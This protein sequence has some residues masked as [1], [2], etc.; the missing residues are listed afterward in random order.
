MKVSDDRLFATLRM[1]KKAWICC[2]CCLIAGLL[3]GYFVAIARDG[4]VIANTLA[5]FQLTETGEASERAFQAYQ[6]ERSPVAIYAFTEAL[7]R[8]QS[9]EEFGA[10]PFYTKRMM[11]FDGL[12]LH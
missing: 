9:A 6:H 3:T 2:C 5:C 10:T 7:D 8:L 4:R 11:A 12:L 1:S